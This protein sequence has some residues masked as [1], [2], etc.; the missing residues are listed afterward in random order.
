MLRSGR[1]RLSGG[2]EV[3]E[4]YIGGEKPGKRGRGAEGKALVVIAAQVEN[5]RIGRIRL[6][7]VPDASGQSLEGAVQQMVQE[8]SVIRTDGWK[9]YNNLE[10]LGYEHEI[11]YQEADVGDNLLLPRCHKV[12]SLLK[13]WLLGTHQ[14]GT[15]PHFSYAPLGGDNQGHPAAPSHRWYRIATSTCA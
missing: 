6:K 1:D 15:S 8:G 11:V 12:A 3:D 4:T 14:G 7:L 10:D 2:I 5:T 9:G 13:R